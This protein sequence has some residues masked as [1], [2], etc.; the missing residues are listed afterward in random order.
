[1][2]KQNAFLARV[3]AEK[4]KYARAAVRWSEQNM[5]DLA[6]VVLNEQFGF[7]ADRLETFNHAME[8]LHDEY[9][10]L[11]NSDT[12][13]VE[14]SKAVLDRRLQKIYREKFVPWKERYCR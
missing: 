11:W 6:S 8:D 4:Q 14:Y 7:G 10:N 12:D 5:M 3:E 1:M 9:A 2:G 13:D